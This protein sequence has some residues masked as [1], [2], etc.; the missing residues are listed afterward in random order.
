MSSNLSAGIFVRELGY[1]E[2]LQVLMDRHRPTHTVGA[3]DLLGKTDPEQWRT[4]L[5]KLQQR[6]PLLSVRIQ[7]SQQNILAFYHVEGAAVPFRMIRG[8]A[9]WQREVERELALAFNTAEAPLI[10]V[11]LLHESEK[12]VL[13]LSVHHAIGDGLAIQY[14]FRDLLMALGDEVLDSLP[15][16]PSI[17]TLLSGLPT[18]NTVHDQPKLSRRKPATYVSK[19]AKPHLSYLRLNK[20][21][22]EALRE[23]AR[24]EKSTVHSALCA[25]VAMWIREYS[26][27]RKDEPIRIGFPASARQRLRAG[28]ACVLCIMGGSMTFPLDSSW[29]FW[30]MARFAKE[31]T[32]RLSLNKIR[33]TVD[34]WEKLLQRKPDPLRYWKLARRIREKSRA[35]QML[36]MVQATM[37]SWRQSVER[38]PDVATIACAMTNV[39]GHDAMVSTLGETPYDTSFPG[40]L[41]LETIWPAGSPLGLETPMIFST[42]T[43][44]RLCLT[45][46]GYEPRPA[47]LSGMH[48][49]LEQACMVDS[50]Q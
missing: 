10:R 46:S 31:A 25:A 7:F 18:S 41:R 39:F 43:N 48:D 28:E 22:T 16:P 21:L 8:T 32:P 29:N 34:G 27:K 12:A 5:Y 1:G 13:I 30:E 50:S 37:E 35:T 23:R 11:T 33:A 45:I 38:N 2:R 4:A 20:S 47:M 14:L 19:Q 6:H 40:G 17:E 15:V 24:Q 36:G 9:S 3:V 44:D 49:L 42:L 26:P